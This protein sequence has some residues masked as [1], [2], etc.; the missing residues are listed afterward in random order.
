MNRIYGETDIYCNE[1]KLGYIT[2]KIDY[3]DG[4]YIGTDKTIYLIKNN[5]DTLQM[6]CIIEAWENT[7]TVDLF[8]KK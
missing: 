7:L 3:N 5:L 2:T 4:K 8:T 6:N 1:D